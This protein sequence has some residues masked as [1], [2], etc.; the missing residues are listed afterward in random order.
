VLNF[1]KEEKNEMESKLE[2]NGISQDF[3]F[4]SRDAIECMVKVMIG[5]RTIKRET[6]M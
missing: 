3:V 2:G 5:S 1:G 4:A 6:L